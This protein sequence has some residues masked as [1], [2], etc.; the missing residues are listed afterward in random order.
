MWSDEVNNILK[1]WSRW[2]ISLKFF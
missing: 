1:Q 2:N